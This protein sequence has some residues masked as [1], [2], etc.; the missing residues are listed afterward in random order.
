MNTIINTILKHELAIGL[1][2][3]NFTLACATI[4]KI[5]F[6]QFNLGTMNIVLLIQ[7]S[8]LVYALLTKKWLLALCLPISIGLQIF[9]S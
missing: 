5:D 6:F 2:L 7:L 3:I 8:T 1:A 9:L 4:A